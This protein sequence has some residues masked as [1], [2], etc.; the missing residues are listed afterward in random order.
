MTFG[1]VLTVSHRI[2]FFSISI[3]AITE[4]RGG[5]HRTCRRG[6]SI[7]LPGNVCIKIFSYSPLLL[8]HN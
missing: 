8:N 2:R 7:K 5:N 3:G 6:A 1:P 4:K